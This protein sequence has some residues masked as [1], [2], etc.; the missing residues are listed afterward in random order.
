MQSHGKRRQR[1]TR[2]RALGQVPRVSFVPSAKRITMTF[3][4][5]LTLAESAAGVGNYWFYRLNS[6]YDPDAS[7]VGA[8]AVGYNTWAALFLNY[9][10]SRVTAR[11]DGIV[12]GLLTGGVGVVTV[13]PV[14]AQMVIPA[15]KQTWRTIPGSVMRTVNDESLGGHN[16]FQVTRTYDLAHVAGVT[17]SQYKNDMD[18]SGSVGSNPARQLYLVVT[19][20]SVG[21]SSACTLVANVALSYMVEW[22]NP[23]PMQ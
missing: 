12:Y 4:T 11:I 1:R 14:P 6:V 19:V 16:H 3:S 17:N 9:K 23:T 10:V 21:P 7:G 20:D 5:T 8:V 15:N 22:F 18:F 2:G 13:S